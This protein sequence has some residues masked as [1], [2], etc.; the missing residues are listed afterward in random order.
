MKG[1]EVESGTKC[2]LVSETTP[3]PSQFKNKDGSTK[4]QDVAKIKFGD[5]EALNINLNRATVNALVDA[6]GEESAEW[7]GKALTAQ[8]EKVVVGGKRVTA[9]YLVPEGF[10]M[11]EDANGYVVI[12]RKGEEIAT[13]ESDEIDPNQVPF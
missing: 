11:S 6:F 10:A 2:V 5:S 1:S 7:Q 13:V 9:V 12:G 8:T 4:V 3:T